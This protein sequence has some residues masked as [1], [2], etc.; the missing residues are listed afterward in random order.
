MN[1]L[2]ITTFKYKNYVFEIYMNNGKIDVKSICG[3]VP[4]TI[5]NEVKKICFNKN[6]IKTDLG[7]KITKENLLRSLVT[8][9]L[10]IGLFVGAYQREEIDKIKE[11]DLSEELITTLEIDIDKISEE[12]DLEIY[13]EYL[14]AIYTNPYLTSADKKEFLKRFDYINENK[15]NINFEELYQTLSTIKIIR[16]DEKN[17]NI[18]GNFVIDNHGN[19]IINLYAGS[20]NETLIHEHYHAIKYNTYYWDDVYYYNNQFIGN[21]EYQILSEEEKLKCMKKNILGNMIEEAHT[22]I[23]TAKEDNTKNIDYAYEQEVYLYKMYEKIFGYTT[24]EK[25]MLSPNQAAGFLNAFLEVGCTKEEAIAFVARLDL[26][27]ELLSSNLDI[28]LSNIRYQVCDDLMYVYQ[29]KYGHTNDIILAATID[30]ISVNIN[31]EGLYLLEKDCS[32]KELMNDAMNG[33]IQIIN[34]IDENVVIDKYINY[35]INSLEIDYFSEENPILYIKTDSFYTLKFKINKESEQLVLCDVSH[36][37][38]KMQLFQNM[39]EDYLVYANNT[40]NDSNYCKYFSLLYANSNI[41]LDEKM[42]FLEYYS[43][44][45]ESDFEDERLVNFL[46]ANKSAKIRKY[47]ISKQ[48]KLEQSR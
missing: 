21:D 22:S 38:E 28:D 10:C 30:S 9:T 11:T 19:P 44:F 33:E 14:N 1:A 37:S 5:I 6:K 36:D 45:G 27:N 13:S 16:H 26:F 48:N 4:Q 32:S 7:F 39:Y 25:I 18:L 31:Q 24:M 43:Y 17:G 3:Y 41:E 29:K 2:Y 40:Y 8:Q 15:N 20:T 35:G 23:L 46:L 42:E 47:L 34:Y 12:Y